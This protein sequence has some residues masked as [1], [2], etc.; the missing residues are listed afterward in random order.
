M[1]DKLSVLG[2]W[3]FDQSKNYELSRVNHELSKLLFS[4]LHAI[5]NGCK[6]RNVTNDYAEI[7]YL[8]S[9]VKFFRNKNDA[10]DYAIENK[11][12]SLS[13]SQDRLVDAQK[14]QDE[15]QSNEYQKFIELLKSSNN[16]YA[17]RYVFM[18]EKNE[19]LIK[20]GIE[21]IKRTVAEY[22]REIERLSSMKD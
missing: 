15:L 10:L 20:C 13:Q 9:W 7:E 3:F 1:A 6:C 19:H 11:N 5:K 8:S 22:T 2:W 14:A 18:A 4:R 16:I 12:R 21:S 17:K